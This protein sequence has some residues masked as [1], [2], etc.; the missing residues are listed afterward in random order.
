ML[1]GPVSWTIF[2]IAGYLVAEAACVAGTLEQNVGGFNL[3]V[4]VVV[5]LA[6]IAAAVT[7]WAA[8]WGYR[9]RRAADAD[10]DDSEDL[11]TFLATATMLLNGLFL[12]AIVITAVAMFFIL[13]CQWT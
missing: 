11:H 10:M 6:L 13:P 8:L 12:L 9:R 5:A 4:I 7:A 2:F 1:V 3:V